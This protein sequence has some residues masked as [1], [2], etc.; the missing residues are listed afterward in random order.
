MTTSTLPGGRT[1]EEFA[2]EAERITNNALAEEWVSLYHPSA[3]TEWIIDGQLFRCEGTAEIRQVAG[4][5]AGAWRANNLQVSKTVECAS[6]GTVVL[7]WTGE[8]AG[9]AG[10]MGTE[11]WTFAGGRAVYHRMYA[12]RRVSPQ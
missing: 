5:L 12:F 3:V 8:F 10:T 6:D 11:I 2:A 4:M 1:A 9:H 7:S